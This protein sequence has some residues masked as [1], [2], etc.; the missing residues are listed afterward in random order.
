FRSNDIVGRVG[1]DEFS[2]LMKNIP[3]T[4]SV[5]K[6]GTELSRL[7]RQTYVGEKQ[8]CKISCS[9]GMIIKEA[10]TDDTFEALYRKAD[11]ALYEAKQSGK[12]RFVLYQAGDADSYPIESTKTD[13]EDLQSLKKSRTLEAYIFEL[14]YTARDFESSINMALA[15]IGQQFAVSRVSIFE[16][17]EDGRTT[18]NLYEWCNE[19]VSSEL[20][21]MQQLELF[22]GNTS[23]MDCFD[24]NGLLYCNDVRELPPYVREIL[25]R[26]HV[27]ATLQVTIFNDEQVFGFISFDDCNLRRVWTSEEIEKLS[28]LS[29]ILS[30]FL[31]KKKAED[32]LGK[33]HP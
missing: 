1:G 2:V 25:E 21:N 32:A 18:R 5:L 20:E 12:N 11:A 28:Y 27:L 7:F 33:L 22:S 8:Q 9:I 19:G 10:D 26:Q 14:L 23:I 29:K 24:K 3:D 30:V 4:A 17:R 31:F 15:A 16:H 13:D 6:K